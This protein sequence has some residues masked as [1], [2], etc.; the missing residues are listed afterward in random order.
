[1]VEV[2]ELLLETLLPGTLLLETTRGVERFLAGECA[3]AGIKAERGDGY[4]V[5]HGDLT[6]VAGLRLYSAAAAPLD[7]LEE[8]LGGRPVRFRV[9]EVDGRWEIRDRLV[10]ERG[11]VNEPRDWEINIREVDGQVVGELGALFRTR[12]FGDLQRVPASTT[13]VVAALIS[14]LARVEDGQL[15]WDPFCGA[16]TLLVEIARVAKPRL[17]ASDIDRRALAAARANL[18]GTPAR[19]ERRDA[20]KAPVRSGSVDRVVANLPFGKRVGTR[21]ETEALYPA[22]AAELGRVL[23]PGGRAVL[24]TEAKR[25]FRE[26]LPAGLR[27]TDEVVVEIGGLLPTIFVVGRA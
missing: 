23:A 6:G 26:S 22:F 8:A 21:G 9:G 11:W 15:V 14:D 16:G 12:R 1:M 2:A 7:A 4:V 17:L 20:R 24:L 13:P 18:S 25:L 27:I 10:A 5:A 19:I 3:R